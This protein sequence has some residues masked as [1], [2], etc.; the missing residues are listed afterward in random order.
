[1]SEKKRSKVPATLPYPPL[2]RD[3]KDRAAAVEA[4]HRLYLF[5]REE[6]YPALAVFAAYKAVQKLDE[7]AI[8]DEGLALDGPDYPGATALPLWVRDG[9]WFTLEKYV[10]NL[11]QKPSSDKQTPISFSSALEKHWTTYAR[12]FHV[13]TLQHEHSISIDA[14]CSKAAGQV[15][16]LT[17]RHMRREFDKVDD[18]IRQANEKAGKAYESSEGTPLTHIEPRDL[19]PTGR[20]LSIFESLHL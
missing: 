2:K 18:L 17:S 20:L 14:A 6:N 13:F 7:E 11:K 9:L 10:L 15:G 5:A 16:G 8:A 4:F 12:W 3:A 1:M 19:V